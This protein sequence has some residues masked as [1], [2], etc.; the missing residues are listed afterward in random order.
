M[1][2]KEDFD[3]VNNRE[4]AILSAHRALKRGDLGPQINLSCPFSARAQAR[5]L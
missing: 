1:A 4:F 3:D 2:Q 5:L